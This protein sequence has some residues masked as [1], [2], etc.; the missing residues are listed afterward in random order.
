VNQGELYFLS[1]TC[2]RYN[3]RPTSTAVTTQTACDTAKNNNNEYIQKLLHMQRHAEY[4]RKGYSICIVVFNGVCQ[5]R[6]QLQLSVC[7]YTYQPQYQCANYTATQTA[8][9][10]VSS[11]AG[12]TR[13][14]TTY[15]SSS[16]NAS[17]KVRSIA[18]FMTSFISK[19]ITSPVTNSITSC[20][21]SVISTF[22]TNSTARPTA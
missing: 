21:I 8:S 5:V 18:I 14:K 13:S 11:V 3:T 20:I 7:N 22:I 1:K 19:S 16:A 6:P 2:L 9:S 10:N 17:E 12:T 15:S 4:V